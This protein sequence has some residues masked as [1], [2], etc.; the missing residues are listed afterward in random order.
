MKYALEYN[1]TDQ[2]TLTVHFD[3]ELIGNPALSE[4]D[5]DIGV[6]HE[7]AAHGDNGVILYDNAENNTDDGTNR[8]ETISHSLKMMGDTI[9]SLKGVRNVE[10]CDYEIIL[11]KSL[12]FEWKWIVNSVVA[13]VL[14]FIE[15]KGKATEVPFNQ[16]DRKNKKEKRKTKP[17][18]I[19]WNF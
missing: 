9:Y 18:E 4:K 14:V 11:E 19:Y 2:N 7:Y 8:K 10:I 3:K 17:V 15:P 12:F 5:M 13:T 1:L 16:N 6:T